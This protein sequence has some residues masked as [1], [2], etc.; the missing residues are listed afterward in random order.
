MVLLLDLDAFGAEVGYD[1]V[2]AALFDGAQAA[3][4]HPQ[5]DESL[6]GFQPKSMGMQIGQESATLAIVRVGN[7]IT[8]FRAFAR[9][10]A[11]SRHGVTFGLERRGQPRFIPGWPI[12][13]NENKPHWAAKRRKRAGRG[14]TTTL[15]R[16]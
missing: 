5:A 16:R 4:R 9:D 8:R 6:L 15:R 10:L 2:H 11:D 1:H 13:S 12:V 7:R 3:R 14:S